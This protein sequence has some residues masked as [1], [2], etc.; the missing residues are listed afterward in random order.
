MVQFT[1]NQ[2]TAPEPMQRSDTHTHT[3]AI[4]LIN[5]TPTVMYAEKK[6][7]ATVLVLQDIVEQPLKV[8]S[9]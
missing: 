4:H 8:P 3:P 7:Q 1:R 9:T 6:I 2:R 5:T